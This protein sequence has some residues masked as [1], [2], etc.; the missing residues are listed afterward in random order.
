[1]GRQT[2]TIVTRVAKI[3]HELEA[4]VIVEE[5]ISVHL[6][7]PMVISHVFGVYGNGAVSYKKD[8]TYFTMRTLRSEPTREHTRT[9]EEE[10]ERRVRTYNATVEN[11][12][13]ANKHYQKPIFTKDEAQQMAQEAFETSFWG[14]N[15]SYKLR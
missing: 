2:D 6:L 10:L 7:E 9:Y 4:S 14:I 3:V 5:G 1:M 13:Q 12:K 8:E 15:E 11:N